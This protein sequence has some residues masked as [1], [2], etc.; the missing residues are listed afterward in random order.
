MATQKATLQRRIKL[1]AQ[2]ESYIVPEVVAGLLTAEEGLN[3]LEA[4]GVQPW[5]AQLKITLAQT[6][7][8]LNLNKKEL[9]AEAKLA[10]Q[11]NRAAVKAAITDFRNGSINSVALE[12]ALLAANQDPLISTLTVA[13]EQAIQ[14][15]KL[16]FTYGQLLTPEASKVLSDQV[17]AVAAQATHSLI[18]P[19]V[20][21]AQLQALNVPQPEVTALI[22]RWFASQ[23][24]DPVPETL[25][26]IK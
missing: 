18:T 23:V 10:N 12:A 22:A 21:Q 4:S 20:A 9:A 25:L 7:A 24:K 11:R 17:A 1:A 5:Y 8:A 6:R 13:T 19:A 16:K 14:Q 2:T 3:A 26:P 15:G